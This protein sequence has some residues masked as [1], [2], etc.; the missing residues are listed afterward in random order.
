MHFLHL[1]EQAITQLHIVDW[2]II[3]SQ[4]DCSGMQPVNH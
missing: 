1:N 3:F 4:K 2:S